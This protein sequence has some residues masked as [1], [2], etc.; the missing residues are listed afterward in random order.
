MK[1]PHF[2]PAN[3]PRSVPAILS[4]SFLCLTLAGCGSFYPKAKEANQGTIPTEDPVPT[5][6]NA[7]DNLVSKSYSS[8]ALSSNFSRSGSVDSV[9]PRSATIVVTPQAEIKS[10]T[11]IMYRLRVPMIAQ[12]SDGATKPFPAAV[13]FKLKGKLDMTFATTAEFAKEGDCRYDLKR[14]LGKCALTSSKKSNA[15]QVDKPYTVA[16]ALINGGDEAAPKWQLHA[17]VTDSAGAELATAASPVAAMA[18]VKG[19]HFGGT[20]EAAILAYKGY[21][22]CT[23]VP[24]SGFQLATPTMEA[25]GSQKPLKPGKD[26]VHGM[27]KSKSDGEAIRCDADGCTLAIK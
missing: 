2:A 13:E 8:A 22:D 6:I 27:C 14:S 1:T 19:L 10:K 26:A 12:L 15:W 25:D 21:P 20:L 24:T 7:W 23:T 5:A 4:T 11:S 9:Q 18:G 16:L 17:K 3:V